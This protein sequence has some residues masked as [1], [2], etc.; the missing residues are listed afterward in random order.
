VLFEHRM[1]LSPGALRLLLLPLGRAPQLETCLPLVLSAQPW[2][3]PHEG[4]ER[5]FMGG[6]SCSLVL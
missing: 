5:G 1:Q 3:V 2:V 6:C 4:A